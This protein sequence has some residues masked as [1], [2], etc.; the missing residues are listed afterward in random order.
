[1]H[2]FNSEINQKYDG[3]MYLGQHVHLVVHGSFASTDRKA[4]VDTM[5]IMYSI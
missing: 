5:L 4:R 1:M 2:V 3:V